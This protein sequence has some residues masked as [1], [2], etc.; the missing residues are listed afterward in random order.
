MLR[1]LLDRVPVHFRI[2][3]FV[4]LITATID[5]AVLNLG[6]LVFSW[7]PLVAT[8]LSFLASNTFGY[9]ANRKWTFR[10]SLKTKK[11][12]QYP[13]YLSMCGIGLIINLA[14]TYWVGKQFG[15]VYYNLAKLLAIMC[16]ALINFYVNNRWIFR[17]QADIR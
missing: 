8:S 10:T 6:V 13:L 17:K 2:Y 11:R 16:I 14:I 7:S 5:F 9:S 12:I 1:K 3:V 4:G 15:E